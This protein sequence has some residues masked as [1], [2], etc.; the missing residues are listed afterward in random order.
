[1]SA[2]PLPDILD[3]ETEARTI[4][5]FFNTLVMERVPESVAKALAVAYIESFNR[6]LG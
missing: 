4:A 1:M 3:P 5:K 6:R 2:E